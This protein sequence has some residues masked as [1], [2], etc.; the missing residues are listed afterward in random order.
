MLDL[1]EL[2]IDERCLVLVALPFL[3]ADALIIFTFLSEGQQFVL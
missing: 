3:A 2:P 1:L